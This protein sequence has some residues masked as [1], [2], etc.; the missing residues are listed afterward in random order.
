MDTKIRISTESQPWRRKFSRRYCR[1]LNQ[2]PFSHESGALTTELFP[3]PTIHCGIYFQQFIDDLNT[4][5]SYTLWNMFS[6]I[7]WWLQH[8]LQLYTVEYI[9]SNLLMTLGLMIAA[10]I[11]AMC[12]H[13]SALCG[14]FTCIEYFDV[15]CIEYFDVYC[16]E[17]FDVYLMWLLMVN[18]DVFIL[19]LLFCFELPKNLLL[20]QQSA[21]KPGIFFILERNNNFKQR[22]YTG[23]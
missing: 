1:D 20:V 19:L 2:G 9:F 4:D 23:W 16:M 11:R 22:K 5:S 15:Y 18:T 14:I 10:V 21:H 17:Y 7:Y 3:S 12:I 8:W 13:F 6:A